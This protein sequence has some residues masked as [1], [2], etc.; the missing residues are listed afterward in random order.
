MIKNI[1]VALDGSDYSKGVMEYGIWLGKRCGARV[2]AIH[3]VDS[4]AVES[5]FLYD[6]SASL[7]FEPMMNFTGK[8]REVLEERG[9][10]I[11]EDFK[12][13]GEGV[14]TLL[15]SGMVSKEICDHAKL[16]DIV[17]LGRFGINAGFEQ[18]LLGS[19]TESVARR[20]ATPVFIAPSKFSEPVKPLV[21]YDGSEHGS[22]ILHRAGEVASLLSLPL[23]VLTVADSEARGGELLKGAE[24]YLEPYGIEA[25]FKYLSEDEA[26]YPPLVIENYYK[27][28]GHDLLFI[29][30]SHHSRIVEMVM[31]S[32]TEHLIRSINTPVFIER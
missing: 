17:L 25:H 12:E 21:A 10:G 18:G 27:E 6:L 19:V 16:A 22:K 5:T 28:N 31:G 20:S 15:A 11:L 3:V 24:E 2:K 30:L 8:M 4:A 9:R 14:E 1:L 13:Y 26:L 29:G 32:T 23:V 7:G